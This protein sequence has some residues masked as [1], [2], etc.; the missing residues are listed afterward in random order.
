[1]LSGNTKSTW[2]GRN[3]REPSTPSATTLVTAPA[4]RE[5]SGSVT[6]KW[7]VPS[8]GSSPASIPACLRQQL[9]AFGIR[10]VDRADHVERLLGVIGVFVG[11][12]FATAAYRLL[13][14]HV[15]AGLARE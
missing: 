9:V 14:R 13:H 10:L 6:R 4:K 12:N 7:I 3:P 1:F 15:F 5:R 8:T 11:Q 2:R